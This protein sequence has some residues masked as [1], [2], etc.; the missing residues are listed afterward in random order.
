MVNWNDPSVLFNDY[1]ALIK[2]DHVIA[3]IYI[4]ETV[5]TVGFELDVLRGKR[6]YKWTIWVSHRDYGLSPP[7]ESN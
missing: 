1:L 4:W 2:L 6:P 3:G 7:P 5:F